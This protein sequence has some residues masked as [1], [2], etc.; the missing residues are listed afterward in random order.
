MNENEKTVVL[1]KPDAH[2]KNVVEY[3]VEIIESHDIVI[4]KRYR[5]P[6]GSVPEEML[7]FHYN[8][9]PDVHRKNAVAYML[10]GDITAL[11]C[12]GENVV[13]RMREL[14]GTSFDPQKCSEGTIRKL[15]S[16]DSGEAS[17]REGRSVRN[18]IHTSDSVQS[19]VR[20][21]DI[22]FGG[23]FSSHCINESGGG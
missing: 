21:I 12:S 15:F 23:R 3:I 8:N 19:A 6:K 14:G 1:L 18:V 10:S 16:R 7:E 22:W 2:E 11:L 9:L 13:E 17:M 20:E 5:C 4:E